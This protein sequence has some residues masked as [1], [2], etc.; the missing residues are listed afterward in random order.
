M[1]MKIK[2]DGMSILQDMVSKY[3]Y[4]IITSFTNKD[5]HSYQDRGPHR[6]DDFS[7]CDFPHHED[8]VKAV[9]EAEKIAQTGK[10][11]LYFWRGYRGF[12]DPNL[13]PITLPGLKMRLMNALQRVSDIS[14]S[15]IEVFHETNIV[16]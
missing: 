7:V 8:F 13:P 4:R 10:R 12:V 1:Q 3:P 9:R 15:E 5:F 16:H 6:D 11:G 2:S 14:D